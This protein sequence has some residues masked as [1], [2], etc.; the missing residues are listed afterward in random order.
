MYDI[1]VTVGMLVLDSRVV[2]SYLSIFFSVFLLQISLT[3]LQDGE[4]G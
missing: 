4:D 3:V 1:H 2:S